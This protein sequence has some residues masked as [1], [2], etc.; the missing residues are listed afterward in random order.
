MRLFRNFALIICLLVGIAASVF[1]GMVVEEAPGDAV[2]GDLSMRV[3]K[4]SPDKG[5]ISAYEPLII[6]IEVANISNEPVRVYKSGYLSDRV[7]VRDD[8]LRLVGESPIPLNQYDRAFGIHLLAPGQKMRAAF[9]PSA[10]YVF[11]KPGN[12]S[13]RIMLLGDSIG[14]ITKPSAIGPVLA[15]V[16]IPVSV[17]PFDGK[18]L[19]K[20]C[21]E[22]IGPRTL[23]PSALPE[24]SSHQ[25]TMALWTVHHNAAL[26]T[27]RFVA[28]HWGEYSARL[29]A[30]AIWQ[31]GTP[32]ASALLKKLASRNDKMGRAAYAIERERPFY[33]MNSYFT[34]WTNVASPQ[35][36][37]PIS[38]IDSISPCIYSIYDSAPGISQAND[39]VEPIKS[40]ELCKILF[41][42]IT[43]NTA[44]DMVD[45]GAASDII[46]GI[47]RINGFWKPVLEELRNGNSWSEPWCI[48][49]LGKMLEGDAMARDNIKANADTP[50]FSQKYV[51]LPAEIVPELITRCKNQNVYL[52]L[53]LI[54]LARARDERC[55]PLFIEM[56]HDSY[57]KSHS[58]SQKFHA[59]VGLVN[60]GKRVGVDW[61]IEH[62]G[63]SFKEVTRALPARRQFLDISCVLALRS[64]AGSNDLTT[65]TDFEN[66]W[67]SSPE[68]FVLNWPISLSE[69]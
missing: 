46:A 3:V 65:K 5:A 34:G 6:E 57:D 37:K 15:E 35:L 28:E 20:R 19:V 41:R 63:K 39:K 48:R 58:D 10:V 1:A 18:R 67:K 61:L 33:P 27:L 44:K 7:E 30:T 60:I 31:I 36:K 14:T 4:I 54:A 51:G 26:P 24:F 62:S 8:Y 68:P 59:A 12:Y 29:T 21:N 22:L 49:I 38:G 50:M 56:L 66:W 64:L 13:V 52:D 16:F 42:Y 23:H 47:G 40:D 17:R 32:E 69:R 9:I 11:K 45:R 2:R 55:E 53:Y 43:S 25:N